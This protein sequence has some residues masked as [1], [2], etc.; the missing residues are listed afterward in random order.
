[1]ERITLLE[2]FLQALFAPALTEGSGLP[3]PVLSLQSRQK[4]G[5]AGPSRQEGFERLQ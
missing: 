2:I 5:S 4:T 3:K 1:V